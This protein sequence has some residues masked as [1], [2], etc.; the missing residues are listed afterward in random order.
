MFALDG[1]KI[2]VNYLQ[3]WDCEGYHTTQNITVSRRLLDLFASYVTTC[4][5]PI[6]N[7]RIITNAEADLF[8]YGEIVNNLDRCLTHTQ[9]LLLVSFLSA[10]GIDCTRIKT[11]RNT[12]LKLRSDK[13]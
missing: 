5:E 3:D 4:R 11:D 10:E 12:L 7:K 9:L 6:L 2:S 1:E 13:K 8:M